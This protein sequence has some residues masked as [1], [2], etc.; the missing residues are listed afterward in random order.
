M[1]LRIRIAS[2]ADSMFLFDLRNHPIVREAS[3]NTSEISLDQHQSWFEKTLRNPDTSIF[4]GYDNSEKRIGMVRFQ[5]TGDKATISVAVSPSVHGKGY[6][7]SLLKECCV[8]YLSKENEVNEII[9]EIKESN[10]R[11][12]KVF[13]KAGFV[14]TKPENDKMNMRLFRVLE[15]Y[16]IGVKI[17]TVNQESFGKLKE[18]YEKKII[19]YVELYI[20]PGVVD[21]KSLDI[22]KEIPII[23]HA[24]N[25][26]H[27]FDLRERNPVFEESLNT[28]KAISEYLGEKMVIFHPG[29]ERGEDDIKHITATLKELRQDYDI[30]LEN[31]PKKPIKGHRGIIASH[32][33]EFE[34][35]VKDTGSKICIDIGHT[36]CSANHYQVDALDYIQ[37]FV[38]LGPFMLHIGDGVYSSRSDVHKPLTE[39]D[40]P[41]AKIVALI[42]PAST[43]TLETPKTDFVL[44]SEDLEN[45]QRLKNLIRA[46]NQ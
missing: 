26:N 45:L 11:S 14:E 30:I 25:I 35:I 6:G 43:I 20:V 5:K 27:G 44:L 38:D 16:R 42:P 10:I 7:T 17:F 22:L 12:M 23:F 9:A 33:D 34:K 8:L 15:H 41:L 18:F 46:R 29:L 24:P 40:F 1:K 28:L 21:K 32:H 4:I 31:M 3:F 39:G 36:I 19:D 13:G 2:E 37:R